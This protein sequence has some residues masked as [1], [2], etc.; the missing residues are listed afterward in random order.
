MKR[1]VARF[2]LVSVLAVVLVTELGWADLMV[3][4]PQNNQGLPLVT[5]L[6][7]PVLFLVGTVHHFRSR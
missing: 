5:R 7:F 1:F 3:L 4:T 2:Y 6:L